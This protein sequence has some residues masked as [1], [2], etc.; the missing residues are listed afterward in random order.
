MFLHWYTVQGVPCSY[1]EVAGKGSSN[2][3]DSTQDEAETEDV[4]IEKKTA[5]WPLGEAVMVSK[6]N[7]KFPPTTRQFATLPQSTLNE[8]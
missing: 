3:S 8:L 7:F 5:E 1:P 2:P 4:W 6:S